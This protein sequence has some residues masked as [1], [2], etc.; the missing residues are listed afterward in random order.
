MA[1]LTERLAIIIEATD[2]GAVK[3]FKNVSSTAKKELGEVDKATTGTRT[4]TG[5]LSKGLDKLGLSSIDAG[6]ALKTGVAAGA[7]VA[8]VAAVKFGKESVQAFSSATAQ[9]TAFKRVAGGTAQDA[10][11]LVAAMNTLH[12][13][14]SA[15]G[16]AFGILSKNIENTPE[17]LRAIGVQVAKNKD[18]TVNLAGTLLNVSDAYNK[19]ADAAEKNNIALTAF[20]RGGQ[21]LAP[22]LARGREGLKEL[23]AE[24][25]K[26]HEIFSD[27]D[28]EAGRR[29]RLA[30]TELSQAMHGLE[31]EAGS[32]LVPALTQVALK[33]T[34]LVEKGDQAANTVG[35]LTHAAAGNAIDG[36]KDSVHEVG[37][38]L[39]IWSDHADKASYKTENLA[40]RAGL[41]A[42]AFVSQGDAIHGTTAELNA[43]SEAQERAN[44]MLLALPGAELAVDQATFSLKGDLADL[45]EKQI[46]YNT[47][48]RDHGAKSAE[49][50]AALRELQGETLTTRG[51]VQHLGQSFADVAEKQKGAALTT[52]ENAQ[53]QIDAL[54]RVESEVPKL[55]PLIEAY[56]AELLR[57][58]G[59]VYTDITARPTGVAY[60]RDKHGVANRA[61]ADGGIFNGPQVRLIGEAGPEAVIPL[62]ASKSARRNALMRQAGLG[63]ADGGIAG[64]NGGTFGGGGSMTVNVYTGANPEE[65]IAAI[66]RYE[67]G[68]GGSW[69][70]S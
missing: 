33:L 6:T 35:K 53:A 21:A 66:K 1:S 56:I 20:G 39:G 19:T 18:G 52:K 23:Y 60:H 65:V 63:W 30:T 13:D 5:L 34:T 24:A 70:A 3:A 37:A 7:T 28:L 51:D 17:K 4:Q 61:T 41:A 25:A 27:A 2:I 26:H 54:Q 69:R 48:L 15:A 12:I 22:I 64:W 29:F 40:G 50:A 8:A 47:A 46:A 14:T 45:T 32:K 44:G 38:G 11:R 9:V 55:T 49:A 10:S 62:S 67:R 42:S 16:K 58:P 68:N 31:I 59:T 57:I 36:F 43:F